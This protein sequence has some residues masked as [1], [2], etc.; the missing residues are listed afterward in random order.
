[1][2]FLHDLAQNLS[3]NARAGCDFKTQKKKS[4]PFSKAVPKSGPKAREPDIVF[5]LNFLPWEAILVIRIDFWPKPREPKFLISILM[6]E[7]TF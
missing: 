7:A 1:M 2:Y 5:F 3:K 4:C 6:K